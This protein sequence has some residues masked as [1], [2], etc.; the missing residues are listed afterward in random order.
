MAQFIVVRGVK[1]TGTQAAIDADRLIS[2]AQIR[3][4][5]PFALTVTVAT[6]ARTESNPYGLQ[7]EKVE[8]PKA[9]VKQ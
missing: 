6:T 7:L 4:A 1:V 9:E 5:F 8:Q 2:V 3:S